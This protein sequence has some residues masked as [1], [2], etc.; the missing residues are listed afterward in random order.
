VVVA[1]GCGGARAQQAAIH[2][3]PR[4]LAQ[5]WEGQASEIAAAAA[6]RNPCRALQLARSLSSD[7]AASQ[8][9]VPAR[10]RAP[11]LDGVNSLAGRITCTVTET[12]PKPPKPPDERHGHHGHH[13]HG[14][15]D[16]NGN[17]GGNGGGNDQ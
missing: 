6:A 12:P 2:Q 3:I 15:G 5:D 13:G 8:T 7:V 14:H 9:K 4:A 1:A 16:G 17:G 10:L 11:L